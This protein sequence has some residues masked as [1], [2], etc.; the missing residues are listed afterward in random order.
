MATLSI[1]SS[2]TRTPRRI[3]QHDRQPIDV[4]DLADPIP[5]RAGLIGRDGP[6]LTEELIGNRGLP[7][8]GRPDDG[9]ARR[10]ATSNR[11]IDLR[12][13][14]QS[15]MH[16]AGSPTASARLWFD[17]EANALLLPCVPME[18]ILLLPARFQFHSR[19]CVTVGMDDIVQIHLQSRSP[20]FVR[21]P[22]SRHARGV[23]QFPHSVLQQADQSMICWPSV[24]SP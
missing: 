6:L 11:A 14:V 9:D 18:G 3:Q 24:R 17:G 23:R 15:P 2:L 10:S 16:R 19:Y 12:G 4:S 7:H 21:P 5:R 22:N 20:A 13:F 1:M 8:I